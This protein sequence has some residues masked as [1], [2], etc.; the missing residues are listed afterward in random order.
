MGDTRKTE[1]V[2]ITLAFPQQGVELGRQCRQFSSFGHKSCSRA[3]FKQELLESLQLVFAFFERQ[4]SLDE[5]LNLP[6]QRAGF[7]KSL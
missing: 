5:V 1:Q 7:T 3:D 4:P 6:R 2:T